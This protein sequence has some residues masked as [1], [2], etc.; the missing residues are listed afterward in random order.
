MASVLSFLRKWN[1]WYRIL[2]HRKGFGRF[3]SVRYGFW[4]TRG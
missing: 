1:G 3:D 2:G 4:L